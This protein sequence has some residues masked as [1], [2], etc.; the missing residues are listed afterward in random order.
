MAERIARN[1]N[2]R[3]RSSKYCPRRDVSPRQELSEST[4]WERTEVI[5]SQTLKNYSELYTHH[6]DALLEFFTI[7]TQTPI[8]QQREKLNQFI[9]KHKG[10]IEILKPAFTKINE[11]ISQQRF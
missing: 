7:K 5:L 2:R 8:D 6:T 11:I 3:G 9:E 10:S 1:L 4:P